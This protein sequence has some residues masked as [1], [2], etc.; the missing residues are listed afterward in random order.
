MADIPS[1]IKGVL[2][3]QGKH[4]KTFVIVGAV[5]GLIV[6][7]YL[8][9]NRA[10]NA[11]A[12]AAATQ[13]QDVGSSNAGGAPVQVGLSNATP[14]GSSGPDLTTN[15]GWEEAAVAYLTGQGINGINA[16]KAVEDYLNGN[17]LSY[18]EYEALNAVIKDL[19]IAPQGTYAPPSYSAPPTSKP[20]VKPKPVKHKKP[21]KTHVHHKPHHSVHPPHK[22]V[23]SV[24]HHVVKTGETPKAIAEQH[25][26]SWNAIHAANKTALGR[27]N[28]RSGMKLVIP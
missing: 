13:A 25:N 12:N 14:T 17:R 10:A 4:G 19:G 23:K 18:A 21:P 15:V 6:V 22:P 27:G 16:Q 1:E 20:P 24:T 9:K 3:P 8:Y 26:V 7:Y 2:R 28:L 5:L 11:A